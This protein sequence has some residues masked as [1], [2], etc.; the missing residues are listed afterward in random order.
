MKKIG[1]VLAAV[2]LLLL[3]IGG[4]GFA[5]GRAY[6]LSRLSRSNTIKSGIRNYLTTIRKDFR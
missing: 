1:K 4:L 6:F 3:L 2:V 5:G